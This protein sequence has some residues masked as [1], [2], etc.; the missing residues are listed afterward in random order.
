MSEPFQV[1]EVRHYYGSANYVAKAWYRTEEEAR[2]AAGKLY[3]EMC[4]EADVVPYAD[5]GAEEEDEDAGPTYSEQGLPAALED[6]YRRW[7]DEEFFCPLDEIEK[8]PWMSKYVIP[9]TQQ[10]LVDFLNQHAFG[11]DYL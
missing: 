5:E 2:C 4:R 10:A 7:N 9:D 8:G 3:V 6:L 1:W 11:D